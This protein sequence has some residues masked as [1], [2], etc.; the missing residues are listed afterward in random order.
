MNKLSNDVFRNELPA[1]ASAL[2]EKHDIEIVAFVNWLNR[3]YFYND[4]HL[5]NQPRYYHISEDTLDMDDRHYLTATEC[6][7]LF[8]KQQIPQL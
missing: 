2:Q 1:S 8:R 5:K 4:F 3:W 6:L 7:D